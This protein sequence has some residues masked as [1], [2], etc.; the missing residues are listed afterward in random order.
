M[1]YPAADIQTTGNYSP[2]KSSK[3]PSFAMW[4]NL[5][6]IMPGTEG[7]MPNYLIDTRI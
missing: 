2:K 3:S 1:K 4:M 5:E 7:T 6:D